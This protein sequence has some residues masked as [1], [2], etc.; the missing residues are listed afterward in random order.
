MM[1]L[2]HRAIPGIVE[3]LKD[4]R[5]WENKNKGHGKRTIEQKREAVIRGIERSLRGERGAQKLEHLDREQGRPVIRVLYAS[6]P[7]PPF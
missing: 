6:Y 3:S 1:N 2:K 5:G 7:L 4:Y